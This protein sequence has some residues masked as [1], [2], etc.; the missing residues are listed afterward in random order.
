MDKA[1]TAIW[2]FM[3]SR[4]ILRDG[5][6]RRRS[7]ASRRIVEEGDDNRPYLFNC[8]LIGDINRTSVLGGGGG[9]GKTR[10]IQI[11]VEIMVVPFVLSPATVRGPAS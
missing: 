7:Q 2:S 1:N 9:G 6:R 8:S 11:R 5:R 10:S 3:W 4:S